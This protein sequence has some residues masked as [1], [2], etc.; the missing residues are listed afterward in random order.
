MYFKS[1]D[2]LLYLFSNSTSEILYFEYYMHLEHD[3]TLHPKVTLI[4]AH[5]FDGSSTT[6]HFKDLVLIIFHL[7]FTPK[8][9][10]AL[11]HSEVWCTIAF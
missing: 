2:L 9:T 7:T 1:R 8:V 11:A 6:L 10:G 4:I 5:H 3:P